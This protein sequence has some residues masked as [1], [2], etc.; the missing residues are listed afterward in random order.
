VFLFE[1]R[2]IDGSAAD[3]PT[4]HSAVPNWSAGDEI[5]LGP[6]RRLCVVRVEEPAVLVVDD[7][8][9]PAGWCQRWQRLATVR[10]MTTYEVILIAR[11]G[12]DAV[13]STC[14]TLEADTVDEAIAVAVAEWKRVEPTLDFAVLLVFQK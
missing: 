13:G 14:D 8:N 10:A 9:D 11:H 1:L 2:R 5:V 4:F 12:S 7:F 6:D 3:P